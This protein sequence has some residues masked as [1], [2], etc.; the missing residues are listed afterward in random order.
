LGKG[1]CGE[2]WEQKNLKDA[3]NLGSQRNREKKRLRIK[4]F[5]LN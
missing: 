1:W 3:R 5:F 4:D 2:G